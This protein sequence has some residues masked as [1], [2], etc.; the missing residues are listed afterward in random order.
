MS[1]KN[2]NKLKSSTVK[3]HVEVLGLHNFIKGFGW[4]CNDGWGRDI[5][6]I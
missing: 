1:G 2:P 6:G 3:S 4:A 5:S